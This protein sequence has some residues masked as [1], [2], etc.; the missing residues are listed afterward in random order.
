MSTQGHLRNTPNG[1]LTRTLTRTRAPARASGNGP[2][3]SG[4]S[5]N[6]C[7]TNTPRGRRRWWAAARAVPGFARACLAANGLMRP[8]GLTRSNARPTSEPAM[9]CHR[10]A[11]E[12]R[13][14]RGVAVAS[15]HSCQDRVLALPTDRAAAGIRP[16]IG[17]V[18]F[19]TA[20]S[21][22]PIRQHRPAALR[23]GSR[24][25]IDA[26]R[27]AAGCGPSLRVRLARARALVAYAYFTRKRRGCRSAC[28]RRRHLCPLY[29]RMQSTCSPPRR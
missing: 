24:T 8:P 7:P 14:R 15:P 13:D 17:A 27:N 5:G 25:R 20:V 16:T 28:S 9:R 12:P 3:Q 1:T 18:G 22:M 19:S 21:E 11:D 6:G 10:A 26:A 23:R 2:L 4:V 29:I